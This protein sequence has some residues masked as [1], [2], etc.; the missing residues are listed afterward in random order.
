MRKWS[1]NA[2][3]QLAVIGA[4]QKREWGVLKDQLRFRWAALKGRAFQAKRT[5]M[6]KHTKVAVNREELFASPARFPPFLQKPLPPFGVSIPLSHSGGDRGFTARALPLH[7][8]QSKH[9]FSPATVI[10]SRWIC[11]LGPSNQSETQDLVGACAL[12]LFWTCEKQNLKPWPSGNRWGLGGTAVTGVAQ[13]KPPWE[14]TK[15][16][17]LLGSG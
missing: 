6:D 16:N 15:L 7:A 12:L 13:V 10:C 9:H 3:G 2:V 1:G 4:G 14:I 8:C 17:Q 5:P 11:G